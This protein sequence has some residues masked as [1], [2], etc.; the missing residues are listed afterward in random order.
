MIKQT[1]Q[2][3]KLTKDAEQ[4]LR[5]LGVAAIYL[6]GSRAEGIARPGSDYDFA[7]IMQDARKAIPYVDALLYNQL[8]DIINAAIAQRD[9]QTIDLVFLQRAPLYYTMNV[10]KYGVLLYD[11]NSKARLQFEER[12]RLMYMDFE[13]YRQEL[14]KATLAMV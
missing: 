13:P 4:K 7:I 2:L 5:A 8:Y 9:F 10:L 12:A 3:I 6:F 14:E 11:G 1:A